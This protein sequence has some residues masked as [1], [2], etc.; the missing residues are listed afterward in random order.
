M[1]SWMAKRQRFSGP[2]WFVRIKLISRSD[3]VQWKASSSSER[4][5][6]RKTA[7]RGA[8]CC[9]TPGAVGGSEAKDIER[10]PFQIGG[11]S[12][13]RRFGI[14]CRRIQGLMPQDICQLTQFAGMPLEIMPR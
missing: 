7:G 11:D 8:V 10:A 6:D 9:R 12:V 13:L 4:C 2:R 5:G 14:H 1:Q 3:R